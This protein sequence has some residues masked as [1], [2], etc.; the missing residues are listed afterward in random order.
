MRSSENHNDLRR[1]TFGSSFRCILAGIL[2][3]SMLAVTGCGG[4][5]IVKHIIKNDGEPGM[6]NSDVTC[7]GTTDTTD[8]DAPKEI[9]SNTLVSLS[10]GF[11]HEDKYDRGKGRYYTFY[12]EPDESGKLYLREDYSADTQDKFEVDQSVL[13]GVQAIIKKYD[14]A[15]TNGIHKVTAGLPP[16]FD[17]CYLEAKYDSGEYISFSENSNPSGDWTGELVDYFAEVMADKGDDKYVTPKITGVITRFCFEYKEDNLYY[18]YDSIEVPKE[19]VNKS[20]ED[21]A[22]NGYDESEAVKMLYR[23]IYD[24]NT[25]SMVEYNY[26]EET[27]E[28]YKGIL[29]II[30]EM[31]IRDFENYN[32]I[33]EI[34]QDGTPS[35]YYDFYIE[36][37]DG[38]KLTG[39]SEEPEEVEA[40][41]P[42]AKRLLDFLNEYHDSHY[43]EVPQ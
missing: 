15:K 22:T 36:F 35:A 12:L 19:G 8:Y 13:D 23:D 7:G 32:S 37:E 17:T 41:K 20:V 4:K 21:I 5:N 28:F 30:S 34:V 18:S 43:I 25:E 11:Y 9:K 27:P 14:L 31:E 26:A 29:D 2:I 10:V 42:M 1:T 24:E 40:F 33:S 38:S 39:A 6:K 3:I 16:E